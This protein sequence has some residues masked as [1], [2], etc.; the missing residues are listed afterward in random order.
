LNILGV[1][2][3]N[4]PKV[5][6]IFTSPSSLTQF[7]SLNRPITI[8]SPI[9]VPQIEEIPPPLAPEIQRFLIYHTFN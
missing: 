1:E 4:T 2:N 6:N 8:E 3:Q 7:S 5:A 9:A